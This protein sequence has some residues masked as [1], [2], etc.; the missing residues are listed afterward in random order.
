MIN[1]KQFVRDK[2]G[3]IKNKKIILP[4]AEDKRIIEASKII[5]ENNIA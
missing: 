2:A 3:R 5:S 1:I 4:E